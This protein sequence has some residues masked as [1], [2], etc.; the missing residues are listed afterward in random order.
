MDSLIRILRLGHR[1]RLMLR[2][3]LW[4]RLIRFKPW[5][6]LRFKLRLRLVVY[7]KRYDGPYGMGGGGACITGICVEACRVRSDFGLGV[8][9]SLARILIGYYCTPAIL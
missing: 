4:L 6:K 7:A 1:L 3:T 9:V 8:A 2:L 5:R